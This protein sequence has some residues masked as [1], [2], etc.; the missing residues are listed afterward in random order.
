MTRLHGAESDESRLVPM[1][2]VSH[3]RPCTFG[4][5]TAKM[6]R[7]V[8]FLDTDRVKRFH[9]GRRNLFT[10]RQLPLERTFCFSHLIQF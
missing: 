10:D 7:R 1:S 8:L 9:F 6:E 2:P 3:F 5:I 4:L